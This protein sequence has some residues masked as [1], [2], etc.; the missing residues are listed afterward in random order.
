MYAP[1]NAAVLGLLNPALSA[2]SISVSIFSISLPDS[3]LL[4]RSSRLM[5]M[6]NLS[7]GMF[8]SFGNR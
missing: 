7:S 6:L 8:T 5:L 2:F 1:I 4:N 3:P